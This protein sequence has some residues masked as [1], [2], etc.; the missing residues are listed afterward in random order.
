MMY[1]QKNNDRLV[2]LV[3]LFF[4]CSTRHVQDNTP[5]LLCFT[6]YILISYNKC[7]YFSFL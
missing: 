2:F 3:F 7:N 6:I 4:C 1:K 5:W